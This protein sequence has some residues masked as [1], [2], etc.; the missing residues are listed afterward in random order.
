M[1]RLCNIIRILCNIAL[2][3][4]AFCIASEKGTDQSLLNFFGAPPAQNTNAPKPFELPPPPQDLQ[5]PPA[6]QPTQAAAQPVPVASSVAAPVTQQPPA[7]A[8]TQAQAPQPAPNVAQEI[9]AQTAPQQAPVAPPVQPEQVPQQQVAP[10][11]QVQQIPQQYAPIPQGQ[12]APQQYPQQAQQMPQMQQA[13]PPPAP[14][15]PPA[16]PSTQRVTSKFK[17]SPIEQVQ[18]KKPQIEPLHKKQADVSEV[19]QSAYLGEYLEPWNNTTDEDDALEFSFENAELTA[20]LWFIE[21]KFNITFITDDVLKP[22]QQGGKSLLGTKISFQT[23]KPLSRREV[24]SIFVALLD[25]AGVTPVP[26][27]DKRTYRLMPFKDPNAPLDAT[28]AP[29]PLFVGVDAS[30]IPDNDTLIRYVYYVEHSNLNAIRAAADALRSASAPEIRAFPDLN[31]LIITDRARIVK[32]MLQLIKE[33]DQTNAQEVVRVVRL[34]HTD[35]EKAAKIYEA[36]VKKDSSQGISRVIGS[37]KASSIADYFSRAARIVPEARSNSL[38]IL[39]PRAAIDAIEKFITSYVD[40]PDVRPN[41]PRYIY[42]LKFLDAKSVEGILTDVLKFRSDS[43][44]AKT[45]GVRD[46]DKYFKPIS[47]VAEPT[48]N[49]LIISAEYDDYIKI[50]DLLLGLDIEQPQ[51]ALQVFLLAVDLNDNKA[52]GVQMRNKIPGVNGLLGDNVNFQSSGLAGVSPITNAGIVENPVGT[53]AT[54][55]LGNLVKLATST[56]IGSTVVTLGSDALGVWGILNML[57]TYT[58]TEII[59]NPFLVTTNKFPAQFEAGEVRYVP[60]ADIFSATNSTQAFTELKG[61]LLVNLTPQISKD[62]LITLD[63][64]ISLKQFIDPDPNSINGDYTERALRTTALVANNEMLVLGGL[65]R[66]QIIENTSKVPVLGSIPIIGWLFKNRVR[67]IQRTSLLVLIY[68]KILQPAAHSEEGYLF[69]RDRI[70]QAFEIADTL[71]EKND[72]R[73]PIHRAFFRDD[74]DFDRSFVKHFEQMSTSYTHAPEEAFVDASQKLDAKVPPLELNPSD[75]AR[76][77]EKM[78]KRS[79][80]DTTALE[81]EYKQE[82]QV[83]EPSR[84]TQD[85]QQVEEGSAQ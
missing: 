78:K 40:L 47:V 24:W 80:Y 62:G 16:P 84:T 57:E 2:F 27:P 83:A 59:D 65:V 33:L 5:A 51:V 13:P 6:P 1:S 20:L 68:P 35:A 9:P 74:K 50:H 56:A 49:S 42:R 19:A 54:R 14:V 64:L 39:A 38:I 55:L 8:Q 44:A 46:G 34:K 85:A 67:T 41:E 81:Q 45:G 43:P 3:S 22:V 58:K 7:V 73:D 75:A 12:L 60:Q 61:T 36:L 72:L 77:Q 69:T 15:L 37:S 31:A 66:E 29:I 17:G 10:M 82:R 70:R 18:F 25:M 53:G 28:R 48:T 21:E 26:G 76:T 32:G 71:R 4:A 30:L 23:H 79:S 63:I 11:P 52:L